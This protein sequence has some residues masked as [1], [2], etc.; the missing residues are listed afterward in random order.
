[1]YIDTATM[2]L[3]PAATIRDAMSTLD[4][5]RLGVAL[6][7][8]D[9]G[10]LIG[11]VSD[12]D[13]RRFLLAGGGLDGHVA[14]A[15]GRSPVTAPADATDDQI[16]A[17]L[18]A[19]H[20]RVVPLVDAVGRP[21]RIVTV[22]ELI[23][24]HTEQTIAVIMAGGQGR[25]L[26][27]LTEHVPKPLITVDGEPILDTL[28]RKLAQAGVTRVYLAVNYLREMIEARF[29]DGGAYGVSIEYLREDSAAGTAGALTLLPVMPNDAFLVINGDIVT[30]VDFVRLRDYHHHHRA[31]LTVAATEFAVEV[32][33]GV[34][35]LG[36]H[37]VLGVDEKPRHTFFCNAGLY[38]MNPELLRLIPTGREYHMTDLLTDVLREG[39][40]VAAFP[41]HESWVDIGQPEQLTEARVRAE[42]A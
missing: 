42:K 17:I 15:M 16:E 4:R 21:V 28:V 10:R 32:P 30:D 38:V 22:K 29:G 8:D 1:M 25:R 7:V 24:H 39:L 12:G 37:H 18:R 41:I 20:V 14:A 2:L 26:R 36:A 3:S 11:T 27:P 23:G 9:A 40:P 33:Y 31:V 5:N 19:G 34:L 6:I 13:I 35:R